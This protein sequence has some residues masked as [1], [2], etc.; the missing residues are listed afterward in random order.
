MATSYIQVTEGADKKVATHSFSEDGETKHVERVTWGAGLITMPTTPQISEESQTSL[1]PMQNDDP[2][3]S[4]LTSNFNSF[5]ASNAVDDDTDTKA[6]DTNGNSPGDYLTIDLGAGVEKDFV[7]CRLYLS[8]SGYDGAFKI[9]YSDDGTN[10]KDTAVTNWTP[11]DSGWNTISWPWVGPHR[12]WRLELVTASSSVHGDFME[13]EWY[14]TDEISIEG[15]ARVVIVPVFSSSSANLQFR[16]YLFDSAGNLIGMTEQ[17]GMDATSVLWKDGER[18][19]A[20]GGIV[21]MENVVGAKTMKIAISTLTAGD[22]SF[23][24]GGV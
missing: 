16:V 13:M 2:S 9:R 20:E 8:A 17:V 19:I 15:K 3:S 12:Y 6:W 24:C 7:R 4:T 1:Y 22:V 14:S 23:Y 18:Y 5:S 11:S 21:V 10:W